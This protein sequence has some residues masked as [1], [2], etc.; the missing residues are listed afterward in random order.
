L[1]GPAETFGI[2]F[3]GGYPAKPDGHGPAPNHPVK[4]Q[5]AFGRDELRIIE[6]FNLTVR[7]QN[8]RSSHHRTSPGTPAD[9]V[10]TDD[11]LP[12]I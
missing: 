4:L 10:D 5:S 11:Y 9:F 7:G 6:A 1:D 12:G 8:N 3:G 2:H